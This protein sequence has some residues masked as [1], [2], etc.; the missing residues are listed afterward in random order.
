MRQDRPAHGGQRKYPFTISPGTAV[1]L[2]VTIAR[3]IALT[4]ADSRR[5]VH[6]LRRTR[7]A[8]GRAGVPSHFC[9]EI[10][11]PR[12]CSLTK[13]VY[14]FV[15]RVSCLDESRRAFIRGVVLTPL[16]WDSVLGPAWIRNLDQGILSLVE[17]ALLDRNGG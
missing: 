14:T 1:I 9:Q 7:H 17:P 2:D 12:H 8:V 13:E 6:T 10:L 16:P 15:D 11:G 5:E 3:R 4:R